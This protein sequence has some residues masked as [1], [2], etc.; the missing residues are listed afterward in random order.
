VILI[1]T[2]IIIDY[3]RGRDAKVAS[4]LP[5]LSAAVCGV[6]RAELLCGA[7]DARHRA[8]LMTL[9]GAFHQIAIPELLWDEIGDHLAQLRSAGVTVPFTDVVISAVAIEN[10]IELWARDAQFGLIQRV[11]PRLKL[12]HEPP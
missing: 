5:T 11:L 8:N 12:F 2:T 1:D 10:D 4:L 9:L 6:V 7:R 3:S